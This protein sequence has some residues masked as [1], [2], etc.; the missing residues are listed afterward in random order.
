[1]NWENKYEVMEFTNMLAEFLACYDKEKSYAE[2]T[3]FVYNYMLD[4]MPQEKMI[5]REYDR[6]INLIAG[7]V[8]KYTGMTYGQALEDAEIYLKDIKNV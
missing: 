8:M 5:E 6:N 1:M 2:I 4:H 7:Y 3:K